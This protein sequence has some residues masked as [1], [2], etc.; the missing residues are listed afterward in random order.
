M[1]MKKA[2][3]ITLNHSLL[4]EARELSINVSQACEKGLESEI[5][6]AR[7]AEWKKA[8]QEAIAEYNER[9]NKSGTFGD[10]HRRF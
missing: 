9:V 8:N 2:T 10:V 4:K 7:E 6:L 3:N 5:R 1:C